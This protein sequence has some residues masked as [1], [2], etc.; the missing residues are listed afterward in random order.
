MRVKRRRKI[1][2]VMKEY[3]ASLVIDS[4]KSAHQF[5]MPQKPVESRIWKIAEVACAAAV[6]AAVIGITRVDA[7]GSVALYKRL[8]H[9]EVSARIENGLNALHRTLQS[10]LE[11]EEK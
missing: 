7:P 10:A 1:D 6:L 8:K 2:S 3:Y 4:P 11:G 5:P 9:T